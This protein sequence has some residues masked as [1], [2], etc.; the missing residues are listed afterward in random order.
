MTTAVRRFL[1]KT[2]FEQ[3]ERGERRP[4]FVT[5]CTRDDVLLAFLA[6]YKRTTLPLSTGGVDRNEWL[7]AMVL[8]TGACSDGTFHEDNTHLPYL[9]DIARAYDAPVM[10][11]SKGTI[12]ATNF[13]ANF[14][15]K[16]HVGDQ[17]RIAAAIDHYEPHIDFDLL[18]NS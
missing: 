14:T 12:E 11:T 6:Y 5:H 1:R 18:L 7:G 16:M 17:A 13:M 15:A 8:C 2:H 9:V 4:L 3:A 10:L